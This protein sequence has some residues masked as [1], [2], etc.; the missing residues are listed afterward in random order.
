MKPYK[1]LPPYKTINNIRSILESLD[2]FTTEYHIGLNNFYQ[3]CRV[4]I[5]NGELGQLN[6]GTNGKGLRTDY[7]L[8]S[9]YGELMERIQNRMILKKCFMPLLRALTNWK[10]TIRYFAKHLEIMDG[11]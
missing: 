5:N 1:A 10:R 11:N 3:S 8:A 9:A 7:A 6:I 4:L 2:I